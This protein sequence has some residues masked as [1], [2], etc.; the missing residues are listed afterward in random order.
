VKRP[1]SP[2]T[3]KEVEVT[4][5]LVN[6]LKRPPIRILIA[7]D[8]DAIRCGVRAF[9]SANRDFEVCGEATNGPD[10]IEKVQALEP[11]IVILDLMMPGI[12]G[13]DASI[14]TRRL[15]PKTRIVVFSMLESA[16]AARE[17]EKDAF[18]SKAAGLVELRAA[19]ERLAESVRAASAHA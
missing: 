10:V 6:R 9:L 17:C 15:A 3:A 19:I 8:H 13:F 2:P 14:E 12:T 7:D 5:D 1:Y 4:P 11:Q 16:A 18:V